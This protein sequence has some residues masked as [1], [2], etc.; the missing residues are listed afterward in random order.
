MSSRKLQNRKKSRLSTYVKAGVIVFGTLFV[1]LIGYELFFAKSGTPAESAASN[2]GSNAT[3]NQPD[4]N[5]PPNSG[6][7]DQPKE[8]IPDSSKANSSKT[9][10]SAGTEKLQPTGDNSERQTSTRES[11]KPQTGSSKLQT[12]STKPADTKKPTAEKPPVNQKQS[13]SAPAVQAPVSSGELP[14]PDIVSP[15][16]WNNYIN[17]GASNGNIVSTGGGNGQPSA[18]GGKKHVIQEGDTL[19]KL[20]RTYYGNDKGINKIAESNG[21]SPDTQLSIGME[22]VIP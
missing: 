12:G 8:N 6:G 1:V 2:R 4:N 10:E 9:N 11:A 14:P 16:E 19:T 21:I 5:Q 20:S 13:P 18:G 7:S 15:E 3:V 17:S 22:L